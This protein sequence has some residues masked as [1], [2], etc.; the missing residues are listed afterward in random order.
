MSQSGCGRVHAAVW[1]RHRPLQL[2]LLSVV[3]SAVL[4]TL[5]PPLAAHAA[6]YTFTP[7]ADAYTRSDAAATNFGV[8]RAVSARTS[9][10]QTR[11]AYLRF[12]VVA[13]AGEKIKSATLTVYSATGGTNVD[14]RDVASDNWTETSLTWNRAP[15][16]NPVPAARAATLAKA[17]TTSFNATSIVT[18][19]GP[20]SMAMTTTSA[21]TTAINSREASKS[22]RPKLVVVT[23]PGILD[24]GLPVPAP[25]P[26]PAPV[27]DPSPATDTTPPD[28]TITSAPTSPTISTSASFSFSGSDDVTAAGALSFQCSYD[29]GAYQG[30]SSIKTYSPVAA[31]PHAVAIRAVDAAG[32]ATRRPHWPPGRSTRPRLRRRTPH[33][34]SRSAAPGRGTRVRRRSI[35]ATRRSRRG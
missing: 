26:A 10:S 6:T 34:R 14:L 2:L 31:G 28:T 19:A 18:G 32:N 15:V 12:N 9:A 22:T 16:F 30:C 24:P 3:L 5:S 8:S 11:H 7:V 23:A 35:R 4:A 1:P 25:A 33:R 27:P 20:A 21:T 29:G 13:P 17:R